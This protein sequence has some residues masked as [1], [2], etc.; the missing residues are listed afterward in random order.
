MSVSMLGVSLNYNNVYVIVLSQDD[1]NQGF[2][3]KIFSLL[4]IKKVLL[5]YCTFTL[6]C[7]VF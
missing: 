7:L 2:V 5:F 3:S 4:F 1:A 6:Y